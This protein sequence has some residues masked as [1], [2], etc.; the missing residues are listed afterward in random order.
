MA[1]SNA[2]GIARPVAASYAGVGGVARR[3]QRT[4]VEKENVVKAVG[5]SYVGLEVP[6]LEIQAVFTHCYC[7]T[8]VTSSAAGEITQCKD[9]ATA[10]QYGSHSISSDGK[11]FTARAPYAGKGLQL[12]GRV[13]ALCSDGLL[14][15]FTAAKGIKTMSVTAS[16]SYSG[17]GSGSWRGW[18]GG[19]FFDAYNLWEFGTKTFT[20]MPGD[21][22]LWINTALAYGS[23]NVT[24]M[25]LG[26]ALI[27]GYEVPIKFVFD[28]F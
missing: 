15:D 10:A 1:V 16:V 7:R 24:T 22:G 27:N 8:G 14:K 25:K 13:K 3:V 17:S 5:K 28:V 18:W 2:Q 12:E 9:A 26:Q 4:Y 21:S 23:Y 20:E 11:T 19:G 6:V